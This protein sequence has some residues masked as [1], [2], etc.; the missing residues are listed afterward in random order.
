MEPTTIFMVIYLVLLTAVN[1]AMMGIFN[2]Q[3]GLKRLPLPQAPKKNIDWE[4]IGLYISGMIPFTKGFLTKLKLKEKLKRKLEAAHLNMSPEAYLNLKLLVMPAFAA[5][6]FLMVGKLE[7]LPILIAISLGYFLPD[8]WLKHMVSKRK[9]AIVR[10]L[11]ETVDL[12]GLCVEAG[13]DF[14]SALKWIIE[15]VQSNSTIE[16]LARVA[17]EIKLGKTRIQALKDMSNRLNI[18]DL[19]TFVQTLVQA[20]RMGTPVSESFRIISED[21]RAMRF[22]R[23]ERVALQAPLKILFPLVFCILPVI[24]IVVAGPLFLQFIQGDVLKGF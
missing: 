12:L 22:Q 18:P 23:S 5:L 6:A 13:L 4:K 2:Q 7:P 8:L 15:R 14:T 20:E 11:P 9:R 16:E 19:N 24:G 17:K 10:Y 1:L 21:T 3:A